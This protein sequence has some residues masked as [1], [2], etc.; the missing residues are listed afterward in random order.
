MRRKVNIGAWVD[1]NFENILR[2]QLYVPQKAHR[3][4]D[5]YHPSISSEQEDDEKKP[6]PE[7]GKRRKNTSR[8]R[9]ARRS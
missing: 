8:R 1:R 7:T 9:K 3:A 5:V 2:H 4:G 6:L